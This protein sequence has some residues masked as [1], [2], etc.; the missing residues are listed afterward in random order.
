MP[1]HKH[2]A[3]NDLY[4]PCGDQ[5]F[6]LFEQMRQELGSWRIVAWKGEVRLKVLREMR[7]GRRKAIS[8]T[9]LDR[10][11]TG[12]GVGS[13]SDFIWFTAD[14]LVRLGIWKEPL[15]VEGKER[16]QGDNRWVA[17]MDVA[18]RRRAARRKRH[19]RKRLLEGQ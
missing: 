2:P 8:L 15:Y 16:V 6:A 3:A 11:T 19:R 4:T 5:M 18:E 9:V 14:D 12:T 10:M 1:E 13:V 7:A 17:E